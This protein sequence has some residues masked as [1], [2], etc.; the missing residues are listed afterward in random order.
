MGRELGSF[1]VFFFSSFACVDHNN[2]L[3]GVVCAR[4]GLPTQ[5]L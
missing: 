3:G 2:A 1:D 5:V 4:G